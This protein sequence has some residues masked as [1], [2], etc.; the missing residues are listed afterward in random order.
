MNT[1]D[2]QTTTLEQKIESLEQKMFYGAF[3]A[4]GNLNMK[5]VLHYVLKGDRRAKFRYI[6]IM[7]EYNQIKKHPGFAEKFNSTVK[8]ETLKKLKLYGS[9]IIRPSKSGNSNSL[10][11]GTVLKLPSVNPINEF[12]EGEQWKALIKREKE[13]N[14]KDLVFYTSKIDMILDNE[15]LHLVGYLEGKVIEHREI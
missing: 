11:F 3:N 10:Y 9:Y 14:V 12:A 2:E 15:T 8:P 7:K 1:I 13:I 5:S 4:R 6:T